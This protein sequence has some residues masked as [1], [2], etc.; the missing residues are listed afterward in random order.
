[1]SNKSGG[2]S[3]V[4]ALPKGGGALQIE[5]KFSPDLHTGTGILR[6][7]L[8]CHLAATASNRN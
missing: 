8:P 4:I 3:Q 2:S 6:C 7:R 1:M 5:E